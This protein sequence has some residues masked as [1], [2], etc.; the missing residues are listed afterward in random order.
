MGTGDCLIEDE[1]EPGEPE[2]EANVVDEKYVKN[3][4]AGSG[5]ECGARG[6][7]V[8]AG[9]CGWSVAYGLV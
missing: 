2:K 5:G 3:R 7:E 4:E 1:M 8:A 9:G 6:N